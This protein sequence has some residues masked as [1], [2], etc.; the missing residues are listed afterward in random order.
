M[1]F[2]SSV[3]FCARRVQSLVTLNSFKSLAG[4]K[5]VRNFSSDISL[6]MLT[7]IEMKSEK[8]DRVRLSGITTGY[9]QAEY[10][11]KAGRLGSFLI[12]VNVKCDG[13]I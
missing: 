6:E 2:N 13:C 7:V 3:A 1:F 4:L 5:S 12:G 9:E 11:R 10:G 8:V